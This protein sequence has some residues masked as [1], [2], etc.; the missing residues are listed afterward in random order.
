[1]EI[2]GSTGAGIRISNEIIVKNSFAF[3]VGHDVG[4]DVGLLMGVT[5]QSTKGSEFGTSTSGFS[6]G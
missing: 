1:M 6:T 2:S 3:H 5:Q 4:M